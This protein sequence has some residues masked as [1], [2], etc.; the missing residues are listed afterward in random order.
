VFTSQEEYAAQVARTVVLT[1][2][3]HTFVARDLQGQTGLYHRQRPGL[4]EG[5]PPAGICRC[6]GSARRRFAITYHLLPYPFEQKRLTSSSAR[7]PARLRPIAWLAFES[8]DQRDRM[9]RFFRITCLRT[10]NPRTIIT[11]WRGVFAS[12]GAG[13]HRGVFEKGAV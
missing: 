1:G 8:P 10:P 11:A 9:V 5:Q 4:H 12:L 7:F 6:P 2:H 13:K 3:M